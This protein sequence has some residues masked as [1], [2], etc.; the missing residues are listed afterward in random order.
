MQM[1]YIYYA[2][3]SCE[4]HTFLVVYSVTIETLG[5]EA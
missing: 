4:R 1:Y 3:R 5:S 2:F